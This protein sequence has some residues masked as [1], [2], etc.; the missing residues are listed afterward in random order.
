MLLNLIETHALQSAV[1]GDW[2]A[3]AST[4]NDIRIEV[5]IGRVGGKAS[6]S[7][8]VAAGIDPNAVIS[9]MR[10]VPMASELLDTL[11]ASGVDWSDS[12]TEFVMSGLV[13]SGKITQET[14]DVMKVLSKREEPVVATSPEE[15]RQVFLADRLHRQMVNTVALMRERVSIDLT[16]E[17]QEAV[18]VQA[19]REAV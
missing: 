6:L 7:A 17:Q 1:A 14:V 15:C 13:A 11:T 19:W 3:V 4:L 8:L 10:S 12:L 2:S 5:R 18:I 16:P 9:A